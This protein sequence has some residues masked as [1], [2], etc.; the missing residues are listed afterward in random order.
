MKLECVR[1]QINWT[2]KW[3]YITSCSFWFE[4]IHLCEFK[5]GSNELRYRDLNK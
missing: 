5:V 4:A 1:Y 3:A 2:L